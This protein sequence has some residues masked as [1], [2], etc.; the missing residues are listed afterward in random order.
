M[1]QNTANQLNKPRLNSFRSIKFYSLF[2]F[3][4]DYWHILKIGNFSLYL[5]TMYDAHMSRRLSHYLLECQRTKNSQGYV[6]LSRTTLIWWSTEYDLNGLKIML[7]IRQRLDVVW[8][9]KLTVKI[10]F[11]GIISHD[12]GY[13]MTQKG[14]A[15][16]VLTT[17]IETSWVSFNSQF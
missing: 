4:G 5:A 6:N 3:D 8:I 14:Q 1:W 13:E 16:I 17:C 9:A 12:Y 11:I 10:C 15:V 2:N 7:S